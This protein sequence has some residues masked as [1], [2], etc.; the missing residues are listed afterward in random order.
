ML[1]NILK[2]LKGYVC[3]VAKAAYIRNRIQTSKDKIK[4]TWNIIN[5]ETGKSST[6]DS[7][8]YL[9]QNDKSI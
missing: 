5:T 1:K 6:G 7:T 9:K 3:N 2:R 4:T 8:E